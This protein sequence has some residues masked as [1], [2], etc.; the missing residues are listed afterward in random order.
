MDRWSLIVIA[1]SIGVGVHASS[2]K[3]YDAEIICQLSNIF[4]HKGLADCRLTLVSQP[5]NINECLTLLRAA[6]GQDI[7]IDQHLAG[8]CGAFHFSDKTVGEILDVICSSYSPRLALVSQS[9]VWRLVAYDAAYEHLKSQQKTQLIQRVF[10]LKHAR[11]DD[12]FIEKVQTIWNLI[13]REQTDVDAAYC[14][15]DTESKKIFVKAP[16]N[17]L[18]EFEN[19]LKEIDCAKPQVRIDALVAI[20]DKNYEYGLGMNWSGIYD[21]QASMNGK[22]DLAT[23]GATAENYGI[24]LV[25]KHD[26]P[27]TLPLTFGGPD[28]NILKL[29]VELH[30]AE[31]E[32]RVRILLKPSVLTSH[33]E[34]AEI[35]IGKSFPIKNIIKKGDD[36]APPIHTI[37]YKDIGTILNVKP[38]VSPN[39]QTVLLDIWVEDS[40]VVSLASADQAPIIK[41]IRTK[42]KVLLKSGQTTVIGG[43]MLNKQEHTKVAIPGLG[44][45]PLLGWMFKHD[46]KIKEDSELLIFITP[47]IV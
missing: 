34:T 10:S 27:L 41:T 30:A 6:S 13:I 28:L 44:K 2:E 9:G 17:A 5:G 39:Q 15:I 19:F 16:K 14:T 36:K 32:D 22:F 46:K 1:C 40:A 42:N 45:V 20:A 35:L 31:N 8:E 3:T 43:L 33:E 11:C 38:S 7:M 29:N 25:R 18:A 21:R 37:E 24:N 4:K 47:T 23:V 12:A 26:S